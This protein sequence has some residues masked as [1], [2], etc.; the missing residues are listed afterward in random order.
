MLRRGTA[1]GVVALMLAA[2]AGEPPAALP[3]QASVSAT[4]DRAATAQAFFSA[5]GGG[6]AGPLIEQSSPGSPARAYAEYW[7]EVVRAERTSSV[8]ERVDVTGSAATL[9][10]QDGSSYAF[11]D[12]EFDWRG[13]L[14]SWV[15]VPGGALARRIV[16]R[17]RAFELGPLRIR[18]LHQFRTPDGDLRVTMVVRNVGRAHTN[19]ARRT[20]RSYASPAGR[21]SVVTIGSGEHTGVVPLAAGEEAAVLV[22]AERAEPGGRLGLL[23]YDDRDSAQE[24]I[25]VR[26]P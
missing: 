16:S 8:P 17:P 12:L 26:L 14:V 24:E 4:D 3:D 23:A 10:Y 6:D 21:R 25:L 22:S 15:N 19:L 13:R 20:P 9:A 5:Y 2:C 7:G 11:D 18:V 1:L